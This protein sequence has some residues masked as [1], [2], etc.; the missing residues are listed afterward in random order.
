MHGGGHSGIEEPNLVPLLDLVL[1]MVMFFMACTNLAMENIKEIVKLPLAQS[2][3]PVEDVGTDI[4]YVNIDDAGNLLVPRDNTYRDGKID[5]MKDKQ[6]DDSGK[7]VAAGKF[8]RPLR[9]RQIE[10]YLRRV[11][12]DNKAIAEKR[13]DDPGKVRTLVIL[14]ASQDAKFSDVYEVLRLCRSVGFSK[15]QLRAT[16]EQ[17]G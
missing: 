6:L 8:D 1:Q 3:K 7:P 10:T 9:N 14:R 5:G 15:M 13:K 16:I 4:L 11:F 17:K 2:A 12:A